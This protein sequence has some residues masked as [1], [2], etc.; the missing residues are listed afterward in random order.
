M[1]QERGRPIWLWIL[2]G[3]IAWAVVLVVAWGVRPVDSTALYSPVADP[4][5]AQAESIDA[6]LADPE[7]GGETIFLNRITCPDTPLGVA[8]GGI[9]DDEPTPQIP[10]GFEY[11]PD[12]CGEAYSS[13]RSAVWVNAIAVLLLIVGAIGLRVTTGR[14]GVASSEADTPVG[15][16]AGD[17]ERVGDHGLGP[18]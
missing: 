3:S 8:V 2:A 9:D 7:R 17:E 4:T 6:V 15:R 5:P 16:Q 12:P 1:T 10:V 18:G 11:E 14:L 13:V